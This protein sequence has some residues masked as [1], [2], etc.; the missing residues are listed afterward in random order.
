M[1]FTLIYLIS[2]KILDGNAALN[3]NKVPMQTDYV[4]EAVD[5]DLLSILHTSIDSTMNLVNRLGD[6]CSGV[7]H[8]VELHIQQ[9]MQFSR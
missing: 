2:D 9:K 7:R 4:A 1:Q 6:T 8:S 5:C 3:F